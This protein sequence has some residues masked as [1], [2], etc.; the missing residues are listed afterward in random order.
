MNFGL[1][2]PRCACLLALPLFVACGDDSAADPTGSTGLGP[3]TSG[4]SGPTTVAD[5]TASSGE[6][7][8]E[9]TASSSTGDST[10]EVPLPAR[11]A[12]TA[13]W[14]G[15][16]LSV[17]DLDALAAG[18]R[19]REEIVTHTIDL[20]GYAPGPLQVELA[21]DGVTAVVSVSPG[22]FG[23]FIGGLVG[24][25]NVEQDGTLLVVDLESGEVTEIETT[26]VP[27]GLAISPDGQRVYTANYGLDDPQGTT[28]TV[29]DLPARTVIEDVEVGSRP[30]QV[31]LNADGSLGALNV[32]GL[33]AVRVFET[34][35]PAGTLSE[36]LVVGNDPSDVDFIAGTTYAVVA[37]SL[38]PSNYVVFDVADPSMPTEVFV[39]PSPLGS[40][41]G[42]TP[43]PGS[44]DMMLTA[45]DFT[46]VYLFRIAVGGDGTGTEVWQSQREGASFPLGV[47]IDADDGLALAA[48]PGLNGVMVV[49][50][51]GVANTLIPWQDAIGPTYV[52]LAP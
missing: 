46:S 23:G 5:D 30:E 37:N 16:S 51:D 14:E 2:H 27:M 49:G 38:D 18:A 29:V 33:G 50:L 34:A 39:G 4:S 31:S 15:Q 1:L 22:F 35:D 9:T 48:L 21:P 52:A 19:T 36:P 3:G 26:H 20:A 11:L 6:T 12:V 10:G 43:I 17:L 47:A 32:V 7:G 44:T 28:M 40:F 24:A 42:A 45:T 8:A 25:V 13:D 41:Y